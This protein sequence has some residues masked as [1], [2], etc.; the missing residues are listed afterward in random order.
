MSELCNYFL[1]LERRGEFHPL[2]ERVFHSPILCRCLAVG[3]DEIVSLV[4]SE[5]RESFALLCYRT[6]V[7]SACL[8]CRNDICFL[9]KNLSSFEETLSDRFGPA[10]RPVDY[11]PLLFQIIETCQEAL[12]LDK[13]LKLIKIDPETFSLFIAPK[14]NERNLRDLESAINYLARMNWALK[15]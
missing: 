12:A 4:N 7:G 5:R 9:L 10:M 11:Y 8:N 6:G 1:G 13:N 14:V 3:E 2:K 15:Q